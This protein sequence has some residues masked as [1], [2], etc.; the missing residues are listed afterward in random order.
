MSSRVLII[1]LDGASPDLVMRWKGHLP[2]LSRLIDRGTSGILESVIPPRSIPAWYCFSTGMNPAKIGVF[3][4]S[5]RIPRTYDYTFANLSFCKAATFW[6]WLNEYGVETILL[7]IPGTFPPHPVNGCLVSGW[8]AP[9]NRGNLTYTSP[10]A[11]SRE[12][13]EFLG[14]PFEFLSS[15]P[16]RMDNEIDA[17]QDRLRVLKVHADVG[18]WLLSNRSWELGVVVLSGLDRASHQFWRHLDPNHPAHDPNADPEMRDAL[19]AIYKECDN[20]IGRFLNHLNDQDTV[21]VVSD[22]GFGPA[23]RT[24][25]INDWLM[26][27]GYLHLKH[28]ASPRGVSS[29][30]KLVGLLANPLFWLNKN[31]QFFRAL[32]NPLK[33]TRLSK[34]IRDEYVRLEKFGRVRI[35]HLPVDWERTSAYCPDEAS[36][37]LN[38]KGRDPMGIIDQGSE[39]EETLMEII[40]RLKGILD[41]ETMEPIKLKVYPKGMIYR[42]P[43]I[44]DAPDL[45]L[46]LD[47][48]ST[49]VMAELGNPSLFT[50]NKDRSGTHTMKGLFIASGPGIKKTQDYRASLMDISPT[51]VFLMGGAIPKESDGRVLLDLFIPGS[52]ALQRDVQKREMG[53]SRSTVSTVLNPEEQ[54]QIER[55]LQDLGYLG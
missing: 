4:F 29:R 3:G 6:E 36:L 40:D 1:G 9:I 21:F 5:Q 30:S 19:L 45:I 41:P 38:L 39:A 51:V 22:H 35:N 2:N 53:L 50:P 17:L 34:Y 24:F 33:K 7:H 37:Y 55:Q 16:I 18:N 44:E 47:D 32:A 26:Q 54:T 8:P 11:L 27:E 14:E 15:L 10:S 28:G 23:N 46:E 20:Q 48:F 49:E 42:G 52:E 43:Y 12:I 25:F 13:D 31:S